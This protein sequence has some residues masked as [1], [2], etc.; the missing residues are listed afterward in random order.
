MPNIDRGLWRRLIARQE[1][2]NDVLARQQAER[3][4]EALEARL[5]DL[6][7]R[8][9]MAPIMSDTGAILGWVDTRPQAPGGR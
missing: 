3:R 1:K 5:A 2:Y 8:R 7:E 4:L 9:G 6:R